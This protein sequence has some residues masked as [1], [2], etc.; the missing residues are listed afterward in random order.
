ML[1]QEDGEVSCGV[2]PVSDD[3]DMYGDGLVH[4]AYFE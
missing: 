2:A 4:T 1:L 3:K